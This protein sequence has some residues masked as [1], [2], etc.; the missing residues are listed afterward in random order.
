MTIRQK[1]KPEDVKAFIEE[2]E[3]PIASFST[4]I[5]PWEDPALR[6]DVVK[7]FNLRMPEAYLVKLRWLNEHISTSMHRFVLNAVT[8]AID[9]KIKE[10]TGK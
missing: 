4:Q 10:L 7:S 1:P 9:A 6:D 3:K 2:P 5:Y 8:T